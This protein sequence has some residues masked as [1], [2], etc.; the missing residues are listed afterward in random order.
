MGDSPRARNASIA[1]VGFDMQN[2]DSTADVDQKERTLLV[3]RKRMLRWIG[4]VLRLFVVEAFLGIEFT[5]VAQAVHQRIEFVAFAPAEF[6][7]LE[8]TDPSSS[9]V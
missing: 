2:T 8:T 4:I 9:R 5:Q 7:F 6:E 1:A 3:E